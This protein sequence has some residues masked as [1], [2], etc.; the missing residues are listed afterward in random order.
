MLCIPTAVPLRSGGQAAG[1]DDP[2]D[3]R[4]VPSMVVPT[5]ALENQLFIAYA[6]HAGPHFAGLSTLADPYGRR[7][8]AA[9]DAAE[10]IVADVDIAVLRRA[11]QD[12]G[13]LSHLN[14][15]APAPAGAPLTTPEGTP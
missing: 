9:G 10:L 2:F 3:T 14:I 11:R 12:T 15:S 13:Y 7:L 4:I 5:R 1:G 6:N 8:A